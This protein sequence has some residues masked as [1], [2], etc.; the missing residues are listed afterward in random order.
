MSSL[1]K[2]KRR[3][4]GS[5]GAPTGT[6]VEG[7]LA[8]NFPGAAGSTA[9]PTLWANDGAGWREVNPTAAINTQ[10]I[11]F[12]AAANI[13]AGFTA[14][15]AL[16]TANKITGDIVIA[17]FGTP[18]QAYVLTDTS[19][20]TVS[21]SWVSLGGSTPFATAAA[22]IAGTSVSDAINPASLAGAAINGS[23]APTAADAGKYVRADATGKIDSSLLSFSPVTFKGTATLTAAPT[24]G[25]T[26]GD[27]GIASANVLAANVNAGWAGISGDVKQGDLIV[28]DGTNYDVISNTVDLSAYVKL[29]GNNAMKA[30]ALLTWTAPATLTTLI[31]GADA[32]KSAIDNMTIDGGTY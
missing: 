27:Y 12:P 31:N 26:A 9:K 32:S 2:I 18:A 4:N 7:E 21:G 10:S 24:L 25:W 8:L 17:T 11:V 23:T 20:P 19:K 16:N 30:D 13:G 6:N 29:S 14:W 15:A 3:I 1:L 5:S 28:F 22:V